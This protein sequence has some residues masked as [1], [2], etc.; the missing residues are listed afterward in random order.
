MADF[1]GKVVVVNWYG[2]IAPAKTPPAI[3]NRLATQAGKAMQSPDMA[4]SLLAE[5][6]EPVAS[7]PAD[8]AAH[9]RAENEQWARVVKAAGIRGN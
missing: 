5:G 4:K 6:S 7:S 3:V 8:F 9:M 2:L 1:R